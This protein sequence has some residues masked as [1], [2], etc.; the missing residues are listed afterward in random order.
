MVQTVM[1]MH[2]DVIV[3][4][5]NRLL[6]SNRIF[7]LLR[8]LPEMETLRVIILRSSNTMI[9][10]YE[11]RTVNAARTEDFINLVR[12]QAANP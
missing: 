7:D 8:A 10:F 4:H 6:N 12:G 3:F 2:P 1:D 5:E 11:K 9:D